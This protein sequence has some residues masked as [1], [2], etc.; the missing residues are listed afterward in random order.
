[1]IYYDN[2]LNILA[3]QKSEEGCRE[4]LKSLANYYSSKATY[5]RTLSFYEEAQE[6][7]HIRDINLTIVMIN[8]GVLFFEMTPQEAKKLILKAT[9]KLKKASPPSI[10]VRMMEKRIRKIHESVQSHNEITGHLKNSGSIPDFRTI[11]SIRSFLSKTNLM[12]S[13]YYFSRI[14]LD[15]E[16]HVFNKQELT[17][18]SVSDAMDLVIP[19]LVMEQ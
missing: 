8:G 6:R 19:S 10:L 17:D 14:L 9:P 18:Q 1:M 16:K 5:S 13:E 3:S 11:Q 2:R 7:G 12:Y 4:S 15:L